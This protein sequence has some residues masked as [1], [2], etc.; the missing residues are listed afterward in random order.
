[1]AVVDAELARGVPARGTPS[2]M[3][4]SL[5]GMLAALIGVMAAGAHRGGF[6][7]LAGTIAAVA[8]GAFLLLCPRAALRLS[9]FLVLVATTKFRE[10]DPMALLS[11]DFDSQVIF[12]LIC[13][14]AVA[15]AIL[16][17]LVPA[18]RRGRAL[19]LT[20]TDLLLGGYVLL[21]LGSAWWSAHAQV[22]VGRAAQL[23]ILYLLC[24]VSVRRLGPGPTLATLAAAVVTYVLLA[25]GLAV[26]FPWAQHQHPGQQFAWFAAHPIDT[27][28]FAGAAALI[29]LTG[30]MYAPKLW[31]GALGR[32]ALWAGLAIC[33]AVMVAAHARAPLF[34]FAAA[35]CALWLRSYLPPRTAALTLGATVLLVGA[36]F[37]VAAT[38][39]NDT[40]AGSD[41]G[42]P[43]VIYVLRG[44]SGEEFLGLSGRM[45]LWDYVVSLVQERPLI[46]HGF[47][48]SRSIL[49]E[50]FPWAGTSHGALPEVLLDLGLAGA[51]LLGLALLKTM[52][53]A[54]ARIGPPGPDA[55][56]EAI[57]MGSLAFLIVLAVAND[58]FAGAP[59]YE[60]LGFLTAAMAHPH[61]RSVA[62]EDP[63]AA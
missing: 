27:A 13:Y 48:A 39:Y 31:R 51:L 62:V 45:E 50:R 46:G 21:A 24:L 59:G 49:L 22:T 7:V 42:N 44:Q 41:L 54:F 14:A 34:A 58:S 30:A 1:M 33:I 35:T 29:L 17:N 32:V 20:R 57:V 2:V 38:S 47:V 25:T 53:S 28:T 3:P 56:A 12:E 9:F 40:A 5:L 23:G 15:L 43:I 52:V 60:V 37:A 10:R 4:A 36:G 63:A 18:L 19:P 55:W 61:L 6:E 16:V 11:G 8:A 26:V